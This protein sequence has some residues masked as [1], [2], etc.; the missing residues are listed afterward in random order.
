MSVH[1]NLIAKMQKDE[2]L[3]L[4]EGQA[5]VV[6][7]LDTERYVMH[8]DV[9]SGVDTPY[10]KQCLSNLCAGATITLGNGIYIAFRLNGLWNLM[11]H[12]E[13][14]K[15]FSVEEYKSPIAL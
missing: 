5:R 3:K 11:Y 14:F 8:G 10:T 2:C 13:F 6:A 15:K 1:K 12:A 4:Q 7:V 9:L